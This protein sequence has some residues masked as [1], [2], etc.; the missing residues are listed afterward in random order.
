MIFRQARWMYHRWR[1][2]SDHHDHD[3][4]E[5]DDS[6]IQDDDDIHGHVDHEY[7]GKVNV[8]QNLITIMNVQDDNDHDNDDHYV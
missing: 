5:D 3:H 6:S 4:E 1:A 2:E 8:P 7:N